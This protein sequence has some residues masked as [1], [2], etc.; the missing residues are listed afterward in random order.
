MRTCRRLIGNALSIFALIEIST[1][2]LRWCFLA[3]AWM[4]GASELWLKLQRTEQQRAV[5]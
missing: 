1:E 5:Y 3:R 4:A 2:D